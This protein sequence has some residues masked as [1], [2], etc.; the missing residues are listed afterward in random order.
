MVTHSVGAMG[1]VYVLTNKSFPGLVKIGMTTQSSVEKRVRQLSTGVPT[2]FVVA[3]QASVPNPNQ[4]ER[5]L[6]R[7]FDNCRVVEDREFFRVSVKEV[8]NAIRQIEVRV[9]ATEDWDEFF[10][11]LNF[12]PSRYQFRIIV[13]I[14]IL[15]IS[16]FVYESWEELGVL[17]FVAAFWLPFFLGGGL[18]GLFEYVNKQKHKPILTAKR[19]EIAEKY[20]IRTDEF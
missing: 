13:A 14:V 15:L 4:T 5:V 7:M 9:A 11:E 1:F 16:V 10:H 6:H 18:N 12:T 3:Y 20:G 17:V 19:A 2:P 8:R